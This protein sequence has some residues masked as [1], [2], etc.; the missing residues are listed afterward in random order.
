MYCGGS[1]RVECIVF[2][3]LKGEDCKVFPLTLLAGYPMAQESQFVSC[4]VVICHRSGASMVTWLEEEASRNRSMTL[5]E[6]GSTKG[7][8]RFTC[9]MR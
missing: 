7:V 2:G 8:V 5:M 1:D 4:F 3:M 6:G 9:E